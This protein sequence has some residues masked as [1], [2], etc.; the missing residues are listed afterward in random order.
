MDRE[1]KPQAQADYPQ[2]RVIDGAGDVVTWTCMAAA[3]LDEITAEEDPA[4]RNPD[5]VREWGGA[6]VGGLWDLKTHCGRGWMC[7]AFIPALMHIL[8]SSSIPGAASGLRKGDAGRQ[9]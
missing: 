4:E 6:P 8:K 2:R 1:A 3:L 7:Y 9:C 5:D